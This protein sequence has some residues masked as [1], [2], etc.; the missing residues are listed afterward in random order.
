MS[1]SAF[2]LDQ[3]NPSQREAVTTTEGPLLILAGAGS[4]KTRAITYRIA[5]L[6]QERQ[7]P[8][9]AILAVTFTNKAAGEMRERVASLAGRAG[10]MVWISTFH[11]ACVRILRQHADRLGVSRTFT[12]ADDDATGRII[13][14]ALAELGVDEKA[15]PPRRVAAVI[16]SAKNRLVGPEGLREIPELR[17]DP[18][19]LRLAQAYELYERSLRASESMDFDD[20][21]LFTVRLLEGHPEV[22][23]GYQELLRYLMVDEYQ[24]TNHAQYRMVQLLSARRRNLCVVG[25]DD[26]SIYRWRGADIS[27]ILNFEHDFP[28]A[29]VVT[30]GENYRSA[31]NILSAA[32]SLISRNEGRKEKDLRA[33]RPAG[34][35]VTAFAAVDERDEAEFIARTVRELSRREGIPLGGF[36]VFY[37]VNAQS[38]SLE[39]AFRRA[40]L[41]YVM[42]GGTRF[43]DRR[44]IRDLLAYL[45][46]LVNPADW[47]SFT[48]VLNAPPRGIGR[49]TEEHIVELGRAR[50]LP[51]EAAAGVTVT[52]GALVRRSAQAVSGFLEVLASLREKAAVQP[53]PE[54]IVSVVTDTGITAALEGENTDEARERLEN[55]QE[56]LSV[57]ED[58]LEDIPPE[59]RQEGL[60]GLSA[61]LDQVSLVA[62]VDGWENRETAVTMMTLHTSKGLEFPVVFLAGMEE[63][64]LPHSRSVGEPAGVEEERRLCYVG[65]TRARE[66][67][68]LTMAQT[69]RL[70]GRV[71]MG[72]PSRF[73][74]EISRDHLEMHADSAAPLGGGVGG[75]L[76]GLSSR[77]GSLFSPPNLPPPDLSPPRPRSPARPPN[78]ESPGPSS[79]ERVLIPI[80]EFTYQEE[81]EEEPFTLGRRVRHPVFG[82]GQVM[83]VE[84]TG[85]DAKVTVYFQGAGKKRLVARYANLTLE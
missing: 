25:D 79:T 3:L 59:E 20:L 61:F 5:Y 75:P 64:L 27:N 15:L 19:G 60:G 49:T 28:E 65:M 21:L 74:G 35:K 30:L 51:P 12:I 85:P 52:E 69:R 1:S 83:S 81:V 42:V 66:R 11:S 33:V 43:Y 53:L 37:R 82:S 9:H 47:G 71:E 36:A 26:Q 2:P 34:Q 46:L 40:G 38:R 32:A 63:N 18:M 7:V 77:H 67:L 76:A 39:D 54:L 45:R 8:P 17:R 57:A 44:E 55:L 78:G 80:E 22:L 31:G 58:F 73:L 48:R 62:D 13:K 23:A 84:G 41:P 72:L 14:Q 6:L 4:G 24:D 50:S 16:G 70:F 29:K 68:F 56:F 10:R